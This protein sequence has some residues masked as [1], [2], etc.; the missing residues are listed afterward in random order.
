MFAH[1]IVYKIDSISIVSIARIDCE[2]V[3]RIWARNLFTHTHSRHSLIPIKKIMFVRTNAKAQVEWF[4]FQQLTA[5]WNYWICHLIET[6]QFYT[7]K[8]ASLSF[9]TLSYIWITCPLPLSHLTNMIIKKFIYIFVDIAQDPNLIEEMFDRGRGKNEQKKRERRESASA[10]SFQAYLVVFKNKCV[11][12]NNILL[13]FGGGRRQ[14]L[15]GR[16]SITINF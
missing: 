4:S 2:L 8:Q 9:L 5:Y 15:P 3:R 10:R 13:H 16:P 14:H 12:I 11:R 1:L 6:P 7:E